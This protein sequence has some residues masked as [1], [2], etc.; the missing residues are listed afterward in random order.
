MSIFSISNITPVGAFC[1]AMD[2]ARESDRRAARHCPSDLDET[3]RGAPAF[4][5]PRSAIRKILGEALRGIGKIAPA[6][7]V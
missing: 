3:T 7:T 4:K 1:D 2:A 6:E 5:I